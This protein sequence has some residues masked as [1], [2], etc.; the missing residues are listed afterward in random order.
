VIILTLNQ[1]WF[2]EEWRQ[3]GHT[4]YSCG[5]NRD[6]DVKVTAPV[7]HIDSI[8]D[9]LPNQA[10]PDVI[11][12]FDNSAPNIFVGLDETLIPTV[13]YSVDTHHHV[14]IHKYLAG[15]YDYTFVAQKDFIKDFH[16]VGQ[17][18][19]WM[20]LYASRYMDASNEKKFGAVFVGNLDRKL[21]PDRVDFFE[22]LKL[23]VPVYC[24]VGRY[25]EVFPYSEIIMNQTVKGDLNFRVFEAM[26]S[27]AMLLTE[28]SG[29][30]L[31]DLFTPGATLEVYEKGNI[32]H[33]ADLIN[34]YIGNLN[35]CRQIGAAG[36]EEILAKHLPIHRAERMLQVMRGLKKKNSQN[37]F[38]A[39]MGNFAILGYRAEGLDSAVA[40][41][42]YLTAMKCL[43]HAIN[44]NEVI[45][46]QLA[47][48]AVLACCKY[49]QYLKTGAGHRM[50]EQLCD[51]YPNEVVLKAS[52]IRGLLNQGQF[53]LAQQVAKALSSDDSSD[54][55]RRAEKLIT[56]ILE[57][58]S[59]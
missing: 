13:F 32:E 54:V 8:I 57:G 34:R 44:A 48:Y 28:N 11:V 33:A 41:R 50:L 18:A 14:N 43:E 9:Q 35:L 49:D 56:M 47:S 52:K 51:F 29:N 37:K 17:D 1:D 5:L 21:N 30:G 25:W 36:R 38:L 6:W 59:L 55:F 31:L 4:V 45:D 23:K 3:A 53:E 7:I 2:A 26:M 15:M 40:A 58:Q 42:S 16:E 10:R 12:A 22:A 39:A 27:G 46:S 24:W 19:E 20:P